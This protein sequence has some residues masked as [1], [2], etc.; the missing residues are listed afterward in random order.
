[1]NYLV[2]GLGNPGEKY[3]KTRHN[4]GWIVLDSAF[5]DLVWKKN[6]YAN[7]LIAGAHAEGLSFEMSPTTEAQVTFV[8]PQTFMNHS[9]ETVE[10]FMKKEGIVSESVIVLYDD[11]D[12]P[13]GSMRISFDRGSGG[14]NGIKSIESHVGGRNFIR[15][16]IGISRAGENGAVVKP[17]VLGNFED[18]ELEKIISL[19]RSVGLV[20]KTIIMHGK[21]KAMTEWNSENPHIRIFKS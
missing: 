7:A 1:M 13:L 21:E 11:I 4:A 2:I 9:G 15:I 10:Y 8:K 3:Q 20:I 19:G 16:R 5:P 6:P 17:N 14:H 12:L 18:E